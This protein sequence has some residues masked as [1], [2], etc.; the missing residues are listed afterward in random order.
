MQPFQR[1][2]ERPAA[3]AS[4]LW[5]DAES[6]DLLRVSIQVRHHGHADFF[7]E[8]ERTGFRRISAGELAN[9]NADDGERPQRHERQG[10]S[11]SDEM[12]STNA[13]RSSQAGT[14][15]EEDGGT[16]PCSIDISSAFHASASEQPLA[17]RRA[18]DGNPGPVRRESA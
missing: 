10:K 1:E 7:E 2:Q 12:P 8:L 16:L 5:E 15:V 6:G 18:A 9:L 3:S 11:D 14:E 4:F 13:R 17:D